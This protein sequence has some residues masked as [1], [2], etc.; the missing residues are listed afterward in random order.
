MADI[1]YSLS[2]DQTEVIFSASTQSGEEWLEAP[3]RSIPV[4][5]A[6]AFREAAQ[7]AGLEVVPFP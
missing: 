7:E 2:D 6:K 4:T 1:T 5:E 3:E